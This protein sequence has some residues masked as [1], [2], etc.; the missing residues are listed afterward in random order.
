MVA[1]YKQKN[2]RLTNHKAGKQAKQNNAIQYL[3]HTNQFSLLR[4]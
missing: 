3:K 4:N 2:R 1:K